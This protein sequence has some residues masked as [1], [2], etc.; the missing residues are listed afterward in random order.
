MKLI[1]YFHPVS[2]S[3]MRGTVPPLTQ[4]AF[5]A[6]WHDNEL[7]HRDKFTFT[8]ITVFLSIHVTRLL[9]LWKV[10][11]CNGISCG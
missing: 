9:G 1:T 4:Y 10:V 11:S 3:R 6:S 2:R 7:K 5:M 8:L